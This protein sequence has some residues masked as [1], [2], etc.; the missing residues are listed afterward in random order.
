MIE[1]WEPLIP[2]ERVSRIAEL[3]YV[4]FP[5]LKTYNA[6]VFTFIV[7]EQSFVKDGELRVYPE[8]A[9]FAIKST[10]PRASFD[11][12]YRGKQLMT[13]SGMW[14]QTWRN[15]EKAREHYVSAREDPAWSP[16]FMT[17]RTHI[18]KIKDLKELI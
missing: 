18:A 10:N 16:M 8:Q 5:D 11:K 6:D 4:A 13:T 7:P 15:E 14:M 9:V 1:D 2:D 17:A 12:F 3:L